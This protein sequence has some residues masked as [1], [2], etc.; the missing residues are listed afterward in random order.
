MLR[1]RKIRKERVSKLAEMIEGG[2][3]ATVHPPT[4]EL[5]SGILAFHIHSIHG[6]EVPSTQKSLGGNSKRL[7]QK[8]R[9]GAAPT[10]ESQA[11]GGSG[12]KLPSSY[13]QV[14]LNDE[15]IFRT[16]TKSLNPRPY[17]NAGSERFIGDW[18]TAR[19]DFTVRDAR[20][21]ES[22]AILGCVGLRLAD[23]LVDSSRSTGWYTLT[24]GLGYGKIRITLLFRSIEISVPRP[25][26][27]WNVGIIEVASLKVTGVPQTLLEKKAVHVSLETVGGKMTTDEIEPYED[28][29]SGVG[30]TQLSLTRGPSRILS[31]CLFVRDTQA[32]Y[33]SACAPTRVCQD[34]TITMHRH[35]CR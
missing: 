28:Y 27:G 35:L 1:K 12:G 10:D 32:R 21:R 19:L 13:V 17:I 24:G 34:D 4:A 5:P 31:V 22:D 26:R 8:A 3:Q 6:L 2:K 15:A 7:S 9:N 20:M 14:F 16:R 29:E 30:R 18:T 25:L 23:V 33:T 11:E